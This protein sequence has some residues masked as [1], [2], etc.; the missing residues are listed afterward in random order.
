MEEGEQPVLPSHGQEG[1]QLLGGPHGAGFGGSTARP[2]GSLDRVGREHL[3][4]LD[5]V[6][7]R[8]TKDRVHVVDR[9][10]RKLPAVLPT[11]GHEVAVQLR[12]GGRAD[13]LELLTSDVRLDVAVDNVLVVLERLGFDLDGVGLDP[14][15]EVLPYADRVPVDV[16]TAASLDPRLV[17]SRLCFIFGGEAADP[18]GFA[19]AGLRIPDADH[20]VPGATSLHYAVAELG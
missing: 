13:G 8:L 1:S 17:T 7:E 6:P 12:D 3:V 14:F 9:S 2:L 19:L 5:R 11:S 15:I 16:L 10:G 4:H 20:V 18:F